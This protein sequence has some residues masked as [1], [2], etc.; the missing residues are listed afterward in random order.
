MRFAL[1]NADLSTV[2]VGF[3]DASQVRDA[4]QIASERRAD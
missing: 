3:S 2:L 4:A 1:D